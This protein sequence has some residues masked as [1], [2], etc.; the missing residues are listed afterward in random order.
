[1]L[2]DDSFKPRG[3]TCSVQCSLQEGET[4][5][6]V[7]LEVTKPSVAHEP[8]LE[9][10]PGLWSS[11]GPWH[12]SWETPPGVLS[13]SPALCAS[14][15]L[16]VIERKRLSRGREFLAV[17]PLERKSQLQLGQAKSPP[18]F[19]PLHEITFISKFPCV[20]LL[21]NSYPVISRVPFPSQGCTRLQDIH[22]GRVYNPWQ[23]SSSPLI[24]VAVCSMPDLWPALTLDEQ[25]VICEKQAPWHLHSTGK[26]LSA[27]CVL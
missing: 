8:R 18:S 25:V 2:S 9:G 17:M 22:N 23:Q 6:R 20:G 24:T 1:M 14:S 5:V 19:F 27:F 26:L 7:H 13:L 12:T 16:N 11:W 4:T 21:G 3:R 10:I 15:Q